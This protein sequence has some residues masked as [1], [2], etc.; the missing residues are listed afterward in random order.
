[1]TYEVP[2]DDT[3]SSITQES[4]HSVASMHPGAPEVNMADAERSQSVGTPP[5]AES[6][7]VE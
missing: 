2:D 3:D 4:F 5:G 1:M 6:R 7:S